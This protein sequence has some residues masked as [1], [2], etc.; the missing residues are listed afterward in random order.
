MTVENLFTD[1]L[2]NLVE[3]QYESYVFSQKL[4]ERDNNLLPIPTAEIKQITLDINYAYEKK[5]EIGY[6]ESFD[7]VLIFSK[8]KRLIKK[9]LLR[10]QKKIIDE[11]DLSPESSNVKWL[12]IKKNL[13]SGKLIDFMLTD[14]KM[15]FV[16]ELDTLL[17][18]SNEKEL[19][20]Y[21]IVT[22]ILIPLALNTVERNV[23]N[24]QHMA[25]FIKHINLDDVSEKVKNNLDKHIQ[26][27]DDSVKSSV[28]YIPK[29]IN[30]IVDAQL[31]KELPPDAIQK[32]KVVMKMRNLMVER[33]PPNTPEK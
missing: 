27:I 8:M 16:N 13:S 12:E 29:S 11:V 1:V 30:I 4:G 7:I 6:Q 20:H 26:E 15:P 5:D 32:A 21:Q 3:A 23:L 22:N 31:L 19:E 14:I 2:N 9:A 18:K 24:H 10:Y 28:K 25:P 17:N 33:V